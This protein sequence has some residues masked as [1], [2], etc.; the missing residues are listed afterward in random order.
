MVPLLSGEL[1]TVP[2]Y[3]CQQDIDVLLTCPRVDDARP[4][5]GL[6]TNGGAGQEGMAGLL[7]RVRQA[8]VQVI[9]L[10]RRSGPV[11]RLVPKAGDAEAGCDEFEVGRGPDLGLE[12]LSKPEV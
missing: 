2:Q 6:I 8:T 4:E 12:V 7:N 11:G 5:H 3:L 10:F 9:E 1:C